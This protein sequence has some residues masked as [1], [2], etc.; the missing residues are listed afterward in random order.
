MVATVN[1]TK[2][3]WNC[4]VNG[5]V[6]NCHSSPKQQI[7]EITLSPQ[8]LLCCC[9]PGFPLCYISEIRKWPNKRGKPRNLGASCHMCHSRLEA[10]ANA[11]HHWECS[12]VCLNC[13]PLNSP[14]IH[15]ITCQ[16]AGALKKEHGYSPIVLNYTKVKEPV[17]ARSQLHHHWGWS[18]WTHI[19][20]IPCMCSKYTTTRCVWAAAVSLGKV[21]PPLQL[22][23]CCCVGD[24][25]LWPPCGRGEKISPQGSINY[26]IT[27]HLYTL[28]RQL[29]WLHLPAR[30]LTLCQL[31]FVFIAVDSWSCPLW[32]ASVSLSG[33]QDVPLMIGYRIIPIYYKKA[34]WFYFHSFGHH[35]CSNNIVCTKVKRVEVLP[36]QSFVLL[37]KVVV[38]THG[39]QTIALAVCSIALDY[40][41]Q[42][43]RWK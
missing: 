32:V 13:F 31:R 23:W 24:P 18:Q 22:W 15:F 39:V 30:I 11:L 41:I 21:V 35:S 26:H 4:V 3:K 7:K 19:L 10:L 38:S 28:N 16:R 27:L 17:R 40:V 1:V 43:Q 25:D 2:L 42:E 12:I 5:K 8:L 34:Y 29:L 37:F 14:F 20:F 6:P 9:S 33:D 36:K